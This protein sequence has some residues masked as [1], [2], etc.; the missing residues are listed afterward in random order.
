MER[1]SGAFNTLTV[2]QQERVNR[3]RKLL[4]EQR[5]AAEAILG[6]IAPNLPQ[7]DTDKD[8]TSYWGSYRHIREIG[9]TLTENLIR[10]LDKDW[11]SVVVKYDADMASR[12]GR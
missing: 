7:D 9:I 2:Q 1:V 12:K 3:I 4:V 6:D 8:G 11:A 5:A 10:F